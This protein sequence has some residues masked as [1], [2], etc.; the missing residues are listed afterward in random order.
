MRLSV[1]YLGLPGGDVKE[2][3]GAGTSLGQLADATEGK[4]REG[5]ISSVVAG[6]TT[7]IDTALAEGRIT[8][9]QA[10]RARS[11]LV[12]RVTKF[13]DH[14]YE[15]RPAKERAKERATELKERAK[16]RAEELKERAK[17]R[18]EELKERAKEFKERAKERAKDQRERAKERREEQKEEQGEEQDQDA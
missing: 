4:S 13:V 15:K 9:E 18:A 11:G 10:E 8:E 1:E 12:E 2:A 17:E 7:L 6:V 14:V 5:L 16:E 3:L